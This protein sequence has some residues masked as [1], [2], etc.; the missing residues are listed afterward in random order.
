MVQIDFLRIRGDLPDGQRGAFEELVSQLARAET[1]HRLTRS[2]E[3]RARVE[4][5]VSSAS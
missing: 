5:G 1:L 2:G 3:S 4:T